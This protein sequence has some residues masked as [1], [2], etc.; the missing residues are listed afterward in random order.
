MPVPL[1]LVAS[2]SPGRK[3]PLMR[4]VAEARFA[5][6]LSLTV[7]AGASGVP[8]AFSVYDAV[9][10]TLASTGGLL[11]IR[12]SLRL[13][14]GYRRRHASLVLKRRTLPGPPGIPSKSWSDPRHQAPA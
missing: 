9:V 8:A 5:L 2:T 14:A 3:P 1:T 7:S 6:S 10:A 13:R 11:A 12:Y 4:T